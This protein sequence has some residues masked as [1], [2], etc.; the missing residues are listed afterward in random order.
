MAVESTAFEATLDEVIDLGNRLLIRVTL[1]NQIDRALHYISEPRAIEYDP[2]A[3]RLE[4]RLTDV[5]R[6]V[7]PGASNV[8]PTMQFIDPNGRA[9]LEI[10]LPAEIVRLV[11]TDGDAKRVSFAKHRIADAAAGGEVVVE[12]GWSDVPYYE[13]PRSSTELTMPSTQW[14]QHLLRA[15]PD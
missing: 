9:E 13:D 3:N 6:V 4:V 14:Q 7:V 12:I 5:G 10:S 15:T 2:D 1:R 11:P 8:A